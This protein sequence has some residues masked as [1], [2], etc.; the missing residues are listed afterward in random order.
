MTF[1]GSK[2][3]PRTEY[4]TYSRIRK[5]KEIN[6][7]LNI[8]HC[9]IHVALVRGTAVGSSTAIQHGRSRI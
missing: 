3:K 4:V 7:L 6:D 5:A 1:R 8:I 2:I 9:H